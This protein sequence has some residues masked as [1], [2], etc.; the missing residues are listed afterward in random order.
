MAQ[1]ELKRLRDQQMA[2]DQ[3]INELNP[4][5]SQAKTSQSRIELQ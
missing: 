1:E 2:K 4:L 3:K 5:A